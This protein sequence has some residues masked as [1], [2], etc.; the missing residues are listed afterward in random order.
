MAI[1]Y[2][3]NTS[4]QTYTEIECRSLDLEV[5][6]IGAIVQIPDKSRVLRTYRFSELAS[7]EGI[8][9]ARSISQR[10]PTDRNYMLVLTLAKH[11]P[12]H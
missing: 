6:E 1:G 12:F 10:A 8:E 11:A 7:S 5:S 3:V 9:R 2:N 4:G